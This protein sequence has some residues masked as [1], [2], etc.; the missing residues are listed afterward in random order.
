[1]HCLSSFPTFRKKYWKSGSFHWTALHKLHYTFPPKKFDGKRCSQRGTFLSEVCTLIE[2]FSALHHDF[3]AGFTKLYYT[4][5]VKFF[6]EKN[7]FRKKSISLPLFGYSV[8]IF[9]RFWQIRRKYIWGKRYFFRE[10]Y[11]L[12]LL[13]LSLTLLDF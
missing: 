5:P 9:P 12:T 11:F 7:V 3:S 4:S 10:K 6:V 1:M 2:K 13:D 8:D